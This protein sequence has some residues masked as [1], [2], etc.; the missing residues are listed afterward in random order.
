MEQKPYNRKHKDLPKILGALVKDPITGFQGV[1]VAYTVY[2]TG[3]NRVMVQPPID[4][5]G[6]IPDAMMIDEETLHILEDSKES[7]E[8]QPK[9]R[10]GPPTRV[11]RSC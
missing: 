2:L 1:A 3:C 7:E 10:G 11:L 5:D 4:K 8:E 6:K 9:D